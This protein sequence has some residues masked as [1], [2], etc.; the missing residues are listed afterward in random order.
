MEQAGLHVHIDSRIC[1]PPGGGDWLGLVQDTV[2]V[3]ERA[4]RSGVPYALRGL[5]LDTDMRGRNNARD[6]QARAISTDYNIHTIW[7]E[8][9]HEALLLRHLLGFHSHRPPPGQSRPALVAQLSSYAKPWDAAQ[10]E[11]VF[12]IDALHR[13]IGV[14]A[15]L[16]HFLGLLGW[17]P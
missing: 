9:D 14:E 12:D 4:A 10:L 15:Q 8:H 2:G 17:P 1:R 11:R 7:Q 13:V 6:T 3:I 16:R 5:L